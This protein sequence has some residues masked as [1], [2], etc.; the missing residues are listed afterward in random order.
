M[1]RYYFNLCNGAEFAEDDEGVE[2]ADHAAAYR[3]AAESLR[4]VMAGD[5][6][7]GDLN[8]ASFIEITDQ[9]HNLIQSVS[10]GEVVDL[11]HD[12]HPGSAANKG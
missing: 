8:T 5:L 2:L 10:F 1:P 6:I 4:D 9:H 3:K 12:A 7:M 11:R